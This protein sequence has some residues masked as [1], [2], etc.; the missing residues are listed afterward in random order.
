VAKPAPGAKPELVAEIMRQIPADYPPEQVTEEAAQKL[1]AR[2]LRAALAWAEGLPEAA[3]QKRAL[4]VAIAH[5]AKSDREAALNFAVQKK[6]QLPAAAGSETT[7][8]LELGKVIDAEVAA[9]LQ[10]DGAKAIAWAKG[11]TDPQVR[12]EVLRGIAI[13]LEALPPS[14]SAPLAMELP[15]DYRT[16]IVTDIAFRWATREM[17]GAIAWVG[18]LPEDALKV[19]TTRSVAVVLLQEDP[20]QM[21]RWLETLQPSPSRDEAVEVFVQGAGEWL[22]VDKAA[23]TKWI[24]ET[25]V[26][27]AEGKE[28]ILGPE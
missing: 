28:K 26:L 13:S 6:A 16:P 8:P 4:A 25:A 20:A 24:R 9:W 3:S 18:A 17:P 27:P 15:A 12:A 14:Q 21:S 7:D 1:A 23:A 11:V 22:R 5:W 19:S 2:D 10:A